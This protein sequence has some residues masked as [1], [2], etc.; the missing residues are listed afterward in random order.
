MPEA[1]SARQKKKAANMSNQALKPVAERAWQGSLAPRGKPQDNWEPT[2]SRERQPLD[3]GWEKEGVEKSKTIPQV[4]MER[5]RYVHRVSLTAGH[6][7][8]NHP[9]LQD[10]GDD[11]GAEE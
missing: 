10:L 11:V 8:K 2:G 4:R 9:A 6:E 7:C 1:T 5:D 3:N